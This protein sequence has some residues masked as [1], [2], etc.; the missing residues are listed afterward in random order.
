[1]RSHHTKDKGDLGVLNASADLAEKGYV[2]LLPL[3]EHTPFDLVA[4]KDGRFLRV[5]VKYR[6]AVNGAILLNL[7]SAW[8]DRRGTHMV[9][10]DKAAID[11]IAIYCPDTRDCYYFDPRT[12]ESSINLRLAPTRNQQSK[13][14]RWASDF[15]CI[16]AHLERGEGS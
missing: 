5:Q 14:V 9:P 12:V 1:M 16:P 15:T 11:L 7:R 10:I 13:R 2:L 4:Y 8:A 6:A 3:S